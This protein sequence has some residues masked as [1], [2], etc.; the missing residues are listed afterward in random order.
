MSPFGRCVQSNAVMHHADFEDGNLFW[1]EVAQL[2]RMAV[3][4]TVKRG[5]T[6]AVG[7][8]APSLEKSRRFVPLR[9]LAVEAG[10]A[11]ADLVGTPR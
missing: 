5:I 3:P 2:K 6:S 10:D 11:V 4:L 8:L 7:D 1:G 9:E